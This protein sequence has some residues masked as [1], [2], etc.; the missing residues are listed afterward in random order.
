MEENIEYYP[1]L[2]LE[3]L[4]EKIGND[5]VCIFGGSA[6]YL[7]I[8]K[9]SNNKIELK[10]IDFEIIL[11]KPNKEIYDMMIKCVTDFSTEYNLTFTC[12]NSTDISHIY[13]FKDN[14]KLTPLNY[15][16]NQSDTFQNKIK[17]DKVYCISFDYIYE[18]TLYYIKCFTIELNYLQNEH[19]TESIKEEIKYFKDKISRK[20]IILEYMNQIKN[21]N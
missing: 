5:L 14:I 17:Y 6:A 8:L 13:F 1:F 3:S 21:E 10:D 18:T 19:Q 20:K 15:F 16:I 11:S 9:L 4:N 7:H 12:D 2:F